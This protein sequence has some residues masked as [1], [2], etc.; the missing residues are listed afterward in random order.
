MVGIFITFFIV[1]AVAITAV[2]VATVYLFETVS[3][4]NTNNQFRLIT[5]YRFL[6]L[7]KFF[8]LCFESVNESWIEEAHFLGPNF[9]D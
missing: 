7:L 1:I 9:G 5:I 6:F 8:A 4:L 3:I 2:A